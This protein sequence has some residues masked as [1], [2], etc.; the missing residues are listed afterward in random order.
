[1]WLREDVAGIDLGDTFIS[2][3]RVRRTRGGLSMTHGGVREYDCGGSEQAVAHEVRQLWSELAMPTR[4][5]CASLRSVSMVMRQFKCPAMPEAELRAALSLQAEE[6]LQMP[7]DR[8]AID[9]HVNPAGSGA[10]TGTIDGTLVAVPRRDVDRQLQIMSLAGLYP[11]VFDAGVMA[12]A[13]LFVDQAP[14]T[15]GEGAVCLVNLSSFTADIA[16]LLGRDWVY[17]HTA[18][19]RAAAWESAPDFLAEHIREIVKYFEA[20]LYREPV[21]SVVLTGQIPAGEEFAESLAVSVGRPVRVWNPM[22]GVG[23]LPRRVRKRMDA[24]PRTVSVMT[25]A[26]GLALRGGW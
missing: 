8:L 4:T 2:A 16:V 13:N 21:N 6:A 12:V 3:A 7:R 23:R 10:G 19:C 11:V 1:M 9:W 17:P 24:S 26:L 18:F 5:V 14:A 22:D 15:A 20:K 25:T